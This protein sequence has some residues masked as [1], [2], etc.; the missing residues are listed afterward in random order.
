MSIQEDAYKIV[1]DEISRGVGFYSRGQERVNDKVDS[2]AN[3][4]VMAFERILKLEEENR[5]LREKMGEQ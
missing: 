2:L 5:E 3:L 4:M 1:E